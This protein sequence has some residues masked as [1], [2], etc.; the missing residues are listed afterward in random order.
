NDR[1]HPKRAQ[2]FAEVEGDVRTDLART[3]D[4]DFADRATLVTKAHDY[5]VSEANR[6][7]RRGAYGA[8][9][10]KHLLSHKAEQVFFCPG[11]VQT[12][13]AVQT[14]SVGRGGCAARWW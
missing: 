3:D 12:A 4:C 1:L 6:L 7:P 5:L 10:K 11:T 14:A 13:G 9:T 2:H 8:R